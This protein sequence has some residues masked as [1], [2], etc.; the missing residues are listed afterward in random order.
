MSQF[1]NRKRRLAE[2]GLPTLVL[3]TAAL[4]LSLFSGSAWAADY[5]VSDGDNVFPADPLGQTTD[6][7]MDPGDFGGTVSSSTFPD[8]GFPR[9][10]SFLCHA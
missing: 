8:C 10:G 4:A 5:K 1:I 3:A 9:S 7:P 6:N 2:L